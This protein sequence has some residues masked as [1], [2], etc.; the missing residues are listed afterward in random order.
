MVSS[1]A[2]INNYFPALTHTFIYQEVIGLRERGV[3]IKAFSIRK[4]TLD[5]LSQESV[6]LYYSTTYLLPVDIYE[7]VRAHL[8]FLLSNP[9]KYI[10]LVAWLMTRRFERRIKDRIRTVFHFCEG[11]YFAK[12]IRRDSDINHIHAHYASHPTTVALVASILTGKTFSFTAHAGDIWT[13]R[14]SLDE[15][16]KR[17]SF[18]ITCSE[19]GRNALLREYFKGD[20]EKIV[21]IRHGVDVR[22]FARRNGKQG[23]GLM[24]LSVERLSPEK[25]HVNLVKACRIL[26]D[27]EVD[28]KCTIVG[29][30]PLLNVIGSLI[31]EMRLEDF[32]RLAGGVFQESI[33]T[34]YEEADVLVVPSIKE[35]LPNVVLEGMAMGLAVVATRI[36]GIP[37]AIRHNETG[38]LIEPGNVEAIV[39][40][41]KKL[42]G[43]H[44]FRKRLGDNAGSFVREY[45]DSEK[46]LSKIESIFKNKGVI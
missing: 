27:E 39:E 22:K 18:V 31:K 23:S 34:F 28:F 41:I 42:S 12:L 1:V 13:D 40:A 21:L 15:K 36:G 9:F 6:D 32:V 26:R 46:S 44:G 30:G 10:S 5:S 24:I 38:L 29:D 37:E 4:P 8:Y 7:F 33:R 11:V 3:P 14:L 45:F 25:A 43:D 20:Q 35:N 16:V 17:A 2:Y 19:F